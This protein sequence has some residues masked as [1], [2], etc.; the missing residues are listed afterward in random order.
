MGKIFLIG[1]SIVDA[2]RGPIRGWGW[3]LPRYVRAG[4]E[5]RNHA[6]SGRSSRSFR[7]EGRFD[8]VEAEMTGGDLLLIQ[9]GHNDESDRPERHTDAETEFP[10]FLRG[11]CE[12]ALRKGA[13]PMLVTPVEREYFE[14][15]HLARETHGAYATAI[16]RLAKETEVPLLD[17]GRDSRAL[18]SAL[19][20]AKTAELFLHLKPGEHPDFPEG[21]EDHN[22]FGEKGADALARL[23]VQEMREYPVCEPFLP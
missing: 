11:Y 10:G 7:E 21:R 5:V 1:D 14:A 23:V 12:A 18:F 16:R 3:A 17:L 2:N 13:Q 8:P 6:M 15:E 22:H 9:F 19:G 4:V 20:E